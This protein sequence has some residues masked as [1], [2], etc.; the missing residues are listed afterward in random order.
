[1]QVEYRLLGRPAPKEA[2]NKY[3][4]SEIFS[5]FLGIFMFGVGRKA[6][7]SLISAAF[8]MALSGISAAKCN[9][10]VGDLQKHLPFAQKMKI[11]D[12][13][14]VSKD[15]C[16]VT[17]EV[18]SRFGNRFVPIF[19]LGPEKGVIVG[20]LFRNKINLTSQVIGK[21]AAQETKKTFMK[22]KGQLKDIV[23]AQYKPKHANGKVLYAFVDPLCPFCHM[24]EKHFKELADKSGYTIDIVPF[25]VHGKPAKEKLFSFVCEHKSFNDWIESKFGKGGEKCKKAEE[26]LKKSYKVVTALHLG[27]TPTFITEDGQMVEGANIP[28]LKQI[29]GVKK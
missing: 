25:I 29:L 28:L 6:R 2:D 7:I 23:I 27:G 1:M 22:V 18:S 13:Q 14:E 19:Y 20:A 3:P 15:V 21:L 16:E 8:M 12:T 10:T 4:S 5:D 17:V 11:L 26:I 9:V 24:A